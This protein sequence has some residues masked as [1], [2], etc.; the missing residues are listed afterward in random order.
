MGSGGVTRLVL[1]VFG[2]VAWADEA[3]DLSDL[4]AGD[5]SPYL[6]ERNTW[7]VTLPV[8]M[9]FVVLWH[10]KKNRRTRFID[11]EEPTNENNENDSDQPNVVSLRRE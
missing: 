6:V 9:L 8:L 7:W 2:A 11:P 3:I 5:L 10:L 4:G 1:L